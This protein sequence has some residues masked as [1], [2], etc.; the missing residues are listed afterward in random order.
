MIVKLK[1]KAE[2]TVE[3]FRLNDD[4]LPALIRRIAD[5]VEVRT[6]GDEGFSVEWDGFE[7]FEGE[8]VVFSGNDVEVLSAEDFAKKYQEVKDAPIFNGFIN[9]VRSWRGTGE[10]RY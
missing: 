9:D 8:Y 10:L 5:V 2:P 1:A 4:N 7:V 6:F 3:A